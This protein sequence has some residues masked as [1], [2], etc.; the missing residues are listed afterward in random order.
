VL[1]T[2]IVA[3]TAIC[4]YLLGGGGA[5]VRRTA[6]KKR[7]V[8][9]TEGYHSNAREWQWHNYDTITRKR[10]KQW[11]RCRN[12]EP[13]V[14]YLPMLIHRWSIQWWRRGGARSISIDNIWTRINKLW[15]RHYL[16][17]H[18]TI[19]HTLPNCHQCAPTR[20]PYTLLYIYI[21][22]RVVHSTCIIMYS[23][24]GFIL[25][26]CAHIGCRK[27]SSSIIP[28]CG[29]FCGVSPGEVTMSVFRPQK[30]TKQS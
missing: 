6:S 21:W 17:P 7:T 13:G 3:I 16:V 30:V 4:K 29:Q 18:Y 20:A 26:Q 5:R 27:L 11:Q 1:C 10:G 9:G 8:L 2:H 12:C 19:T 25:V 23:R 24:V 22:E 28:F 14:S 15:T